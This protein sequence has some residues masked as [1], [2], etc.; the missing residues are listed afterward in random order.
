MTMRCVGPLQRSC[1]KVVRGV[2]SSN[3]AVLVARLSGA[4]S[5]ITAFFF[6]RL[7]EWFRTYLR[8]ST[9]FILAL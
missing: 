3:D 2:H 6:Q 5:F 1:V 8:G 4:C 7:V 9:P